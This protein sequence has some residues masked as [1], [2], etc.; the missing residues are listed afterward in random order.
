MKKKAALLCRV[1]T[2]QQKKNGLESQVSTLLKIAERDGYDVPEELIFQEQ[3]TG[4]DKN[5]PIRESLQALK[6]AIEEEKV[7]ACYIYE[8]T[9]ISRLEFTLVETVH[10]FTQHKI[11]LYIA[12]VDKWTLNPETLEENIDTTN[13]IYGAATYGRNEAEKFVKRTQR[14]RNARAEMGLYVGHLADGYCVDNSQSR[15]VIL[16]DEDRQNVIKEI[17]D[18]CEKGY[19]SDK[20]ADMLNAENIPTTNAY[21][22]SSPKFPGFKDTY[23]LKGG[24]VTLKRTDAKWHGTTISSI[25]KNEWYIGKRKY[26]GKT[27]EIKNPIIELS[28]WEKVQE[29]LSKRAIEYRTEKKSNKHTYILSGLLYCG[30]CGRKLYGHSTGLNNHYYCSSIEDGRKCGLQGVCKE[31]VEAI[32][33]SMLKMH[34][35]TQIFN[36]ENYRKIFSFRKEDIEN[37]KT[38]IDNN[39]ILIEQWEKEKENAE[40]GINLSTRHMIEAEITGDK[41]LIKVYQKQQENFRKELDVCIKKIDNTR[42]D[43]IVLKKKLLFNKN[44]DTI[45]QNI[46][47]VQTPSELHELCRQIIN[48]IDVFN[49]NKTVTILRV[50]FINGETSEVIYAHRLIKHNYIVIHML[51]Y[52][53]RDCLLHTKE[54]T[55]PVFV[56]SSYVSYDDGKP[57]ERELSELKTI[58]EDYYRSKEGIKY[59]PGSDFS[60]YDLYGGVE[61]RDFYVYN[62]P[63]R[64]D[65]FIKNLRDLKSGYILPF[66]RLSEHS[67]KANEQKKHY[68]EWR[69]KYN[70]GLPTSVP[71]VVRDSTY[72]EVCKERKKLYNRIYKI[73]HNKKKTES[74]KKKEI[75]EIEEK[76]SILS[77]KIKYIPRE[78]ALKKY[79]GN[80]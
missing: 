68:K 65:E 73:R 62:S 16:I 49:A 74:Q 57:I 50:N 60:H 22:L 12:D 48:R 36:N 10:F 44:I 19:S 75:E 8:L 17:F 34:A 52:N 21:R 30:K 18:Y 40:K 67:P 58:C 55:Y 4:L 39:N 61:G 33:V 28:L 56:S 13:Y 25:L 15:K 70:T 47:D 72:D 29:K 78:E 63:I 59:L 26:N 80:K 24:K 46:N 69:K 32:I 41:N 77:A 2:P 5:K 76:L 53:E 54:D 79:K 64:V 20:I 27:Y 42:N 43:N 66:S 37:V 71:S 1:S 7:D 31:N 11:P 9:R 38:T 35:I 45:I 6:N 14:G 23:S 3:I 51:K